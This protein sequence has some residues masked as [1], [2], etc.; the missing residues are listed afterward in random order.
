MTAL[1]REAQKRTEK[2]RECGER[3]TAATFVALVLQQMIHRKEHDSA[4]QVGLVSRET[5]CI[6]LRKFANSHWVRRVFYT[7]GCGARHRDIHQAEE[8]G[9]SYPLALHS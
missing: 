9:K 5:R 6:V 4:T 2:Q 1:C 8:T 7:T 3:K